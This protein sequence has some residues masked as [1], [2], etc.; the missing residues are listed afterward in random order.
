[1][2]LCQL[3]SYYEFCL[4]KN[5]RCIIYLNKNT[6]MILA[7]VNLFVIVHYC[8]FINGPKRAQADVWF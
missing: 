4:F 5:I 3:V 7:L 6:D 2:F 8:V 1:M